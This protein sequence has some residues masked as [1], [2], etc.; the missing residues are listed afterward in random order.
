VRRVP[1][2]SRQ[3]LLV[4]FAVA[5]LAVPTSAAGEPSITFERHIVGTLGSNG[6]YVS[7]VHVYWTFSPPPDNQQG[8]DQTITAEG[9][10]H[11]V[12]TAW[13]GQTRIDDPVDISIDKTAPFVTGHPSRSP[14]ANGWY[15]GPVSFTFTGTDATSGLAGCS[16]TSYSGPDNGSVSVTGTCTDNAGNVGRATYSFSYDSTPPTVGSVTA[17]HGNRNVLL[18]WTDSA[19]TQVVQVTRK[20][21]T[22]GPGTVVYRGPG[23]TFRDTGLRPGAK[24]QYT[25]AAFDQAANTGARTLSVTATG[26]LINPVPGERVTSPPRLAW[27]PVKGASYYNVQLLRGGGG[28]ILSA[29]PTKANFKLPRSWVYHGHRYHLKP[30]VYRWYVWP[31]YG[32]LALARYGRLLGGSSFLYAKNG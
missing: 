23:H 25:V 2:A 29:W 27:L 11:L 20:G 5:C 24:Y 12:C 4:L 15:N 8:C 7:N 13:W 18:S 6:W 31:G 14:D 17:K 28:R 1:T 22:S 3:L 9:P 21:A 10:T 30:G 32:K 26:R 19:D 16:S